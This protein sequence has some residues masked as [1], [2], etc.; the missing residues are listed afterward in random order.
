VIALLIFSAG[1][2]GEFAAL[3]ALYYQ[4]VIN[5]LG[6]FFTVFGTFF[7]TA[8]VAAGPFRAVMEFA[9]KGASQA[10]ATQEGVSG[11][12]AS[13]GP[14]GG[15][16]TGVA[17]HAAEV[18]DEIAAL[19][20]TAERLLGAKDPRTLTARKQLAQLTGWAGDA[21]GARDQYAALLPITERV[22][23]PEHP[24]TLSA[25]NQLAHWTGQAAQLSNQPESRSKPSSP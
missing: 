25:R 2:S 15:A 4:R 17:G 8:A 12:R 14:V 22:L 11:G 3:S 20:P 23:G 6:T 5:P 24:D 9:A 10:G 13:P 19:L 16:E 1:L 21:Y 7:L 18:R